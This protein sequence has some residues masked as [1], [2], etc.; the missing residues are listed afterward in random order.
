MLGRRQ[1]EGAPERAAGG[2]QAEE[3]DYQRAERDPGRTKEPGQACDHD[4]D[5]EQSS[6]TMPIDSSRPSA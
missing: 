5:G 1:E 3:N 2:H 6:V 4:R